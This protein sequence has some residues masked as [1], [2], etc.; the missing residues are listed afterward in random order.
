MKRRQF[1][2]YSTAT[3]FGALLVG[4]VDLQ[5]VNESQADSLLARPD[6]L[7]FI[8][9]KQAVITIGKEYRAQYIEEDNAEV[10]RNQLINSLRGCKVVS[11]ELLKQQISADFE[12]G[13]VVCL[14][15]WM[16]SVTEARQ[17]ALF[18]LLHT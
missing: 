9:N 17:C 2:Q 18:S 7:R 13:Q 1:V 5:G 14:K 16:L 8:G 6:L 4:P 12:S 3:A 15:G 11:A 10:L